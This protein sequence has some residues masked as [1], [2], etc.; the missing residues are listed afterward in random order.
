M[1]LLGEGGTGKS[2]DIDAIS[3]TFAFHNEMDLLAKCG[4]S[5]ISSSNIKGQTIHSWAG[6]S[7]RTSKADNW[8][9]KATEAIKSKRSIN[10]LGVEFLILDEIS[11]FTKMLMFYLSG[12]IGTSRGSEGKGG[13]SDPFGGMHVIL[14][15]DFHQFPPVASQNGALYHNDEKDTARAKIGQDIYRQFDTVVILKK[16]MRVSDQIWTDILKR[17]RVGECTKNDLEEIEKLVLT[18]PHCEVPDFTKPPWDEC[19]LITPRHAVRE[20]WNLAAVKQHCNRTS[21]ILYIA[22]AEDTLGNTTAN[23]PLQV[24]VIVAG[25][26]EKKTG[27]LCDR[28]ELAVGMKV[29]VTANIA[30]EADVAN[31]TQGRI[32]QILLDSREPPVILEDGVVQLKYPPAMVLF[33]PDK[34]TDVVLPGVPIG[35]L[36]L[37]PATERFSIT[38]PKPKAETF[39]IRRRQFQLTPGYAFTDYKSQGQ[40]MGA[41]V[42]DIG[43][44]FS[45]TPF[46]VYVALSRSKGRQ[47]IRLLRDFKEE[48]FTTHPS[49]SLRKEIVR[50]EALAEKTKERFKALKMC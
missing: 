2:M 7:P 32:T 25:M 33:R 4:T 26:T 44:S 41:V 30:T 39:R 38:T 16:Q 23:I 24:K 49:E 1:L 17:L 14:C 9:E 11:M 19:I 27:K 40:T 10:I 50:L 35:Q 13:A 22:P 6:I 48:L 12:I 18:N 3:E 15:G 28:L 20:R 29:M 42:V 43:K 45:L 34:G 8:F 37:T 47:N 31:G 5:G 21:N 36:P 46:H